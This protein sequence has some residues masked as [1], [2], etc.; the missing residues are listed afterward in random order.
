[1][2]PS[3][4][5]SSFLLAIS[6]ELA[7]IDAR[8]D[9]LVAEWDPS[10]ATEMLSDWERVLGLPVEGTVLPADNV[11]RQIA[12]ARAYVARGGQT[13]AYFIALAD[14]A[15]FEVSISD[16][17]VHVWQMSVNLSLIR[18]SYTLVTSIFRAGAS[19]A[20]D[21][22][23]SYSVPELEAVIRRATPAHTVVWFRYF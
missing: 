14:A 8:A 13:E 3:S 1:V 21:H 4:G 9:Q 12:V 18:V 16:I 22:L 20:G 7:R 23:T 5:L 10:T 6:D 17:A 11:S 15:G 19:R 2:E